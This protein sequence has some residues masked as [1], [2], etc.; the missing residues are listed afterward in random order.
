LDGSRRDFA[1]IWLALNTRFPQAPGEIP[2]NGIYYD[3]PEEEIYK[4]K[5]ARPSKPEALRIYE[6]HVGMSSPEP[7]VSS[8]G[9]AESSLGDA[10]SSLGDAESSLG[11]AES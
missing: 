7:K 8:L 1:T 5:H 11:D 3:P 2:F 9:D 4:F 6:C 10:K